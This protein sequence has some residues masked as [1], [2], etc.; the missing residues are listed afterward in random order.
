[1]LSLL[2]MFCYLLHF[3]YH[4]CFTFNTLAIKTNIMYIANRNICTHT[5]IYIY[6][7]W[8]RLLHLS[9]PSNIW[10]YK[11]HVANQWQLVFSSC[12]PVPTVA[13]SFHG[14]KSIQLPLVGD[15]SRNSC[16]QQMHE[17]SY[18]E[19]IRYNFGAVSAACCYFEGHKVTLRSIFLR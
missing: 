9:S 14:R 12:E 13:P 15:V 2:Y 7:A 5:H 10:K 1:M 16:S 19:M 4:M 8:C 6:Y 18:L 11:G 17:R 3:L